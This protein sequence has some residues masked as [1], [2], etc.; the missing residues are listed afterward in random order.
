[1]PLAAY[2]RVYFYTIFATEKQ[3]ASAEYMFVSYLLVGEGE[4]Q[5]VLVVLHAR[6]VHE[7]Y[8]AVGYLGHRV[9]APATRR[10]ITNM[11]R[12]RFSN[13]CMNINATSKTDS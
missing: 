3:N 12:W 10:R 11:R 5:V 1:M 4:G 7:L 8:A 13:L 9:A 2:A 6:F